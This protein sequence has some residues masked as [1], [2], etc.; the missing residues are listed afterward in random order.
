MLMLSPLCWQCVTVCSIKC[1]AQ[2]FPEHKSPATGLVVKSTRNIQM[3]RRPGNPP[4]GLRSNRN[5]LSPEILLVVWHGNRR[6]IKN[7]ER[8]RNIK[9]D[10][11]YQSD[12]DFLDAPHVT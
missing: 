11:E 6:K 1:N 7:H 5:L 12:S 4:S 10:D 9:T 8:Q 2:R 3:A